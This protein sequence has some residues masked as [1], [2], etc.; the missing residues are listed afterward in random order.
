MH[1]DDRGQ[2]ATAF[3]AE[4][5]HALHAAGVEFLVGG[6]F[7][8]AQV[9]GLQRATKDLDLFVRRD[10]WPRLDAALAPLGATLEL[11]HPHWLGKAL[12]GPHFVDLIFNSGNGLAPVDDTWFAAAGPAQPLL[13][14]PVRLAPVEETLWTKAFIMERERYDGADVA[15]L[16]LS[17][18]PT[19]DWPR[20]MARFGPHWRVL[21]A[22]L[23][24]FGFVFPG[25]RARVPPWVL[26]EFTA[27][28]LRETHAEPPPTRLCA[29]TLLSREQYLADVAQRG[30]LDVRH[31]P[32]STMQPGDVA[33]WTEAIPPPAHAG[34]PPPA[35]A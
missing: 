26:D 27:R 19:L 20:L 24:L 7:A 29:G 5:L 35:P 31:T 32:L 23:V 17:C 11:T 10:D 33:A 1:D 12:R 25:E 13:G 16:L 9:T 6:A 15:H 4:V 18:G 8:F 34:V 2:A 14:T 30:F 3:Y 22:H 28:L 21:M